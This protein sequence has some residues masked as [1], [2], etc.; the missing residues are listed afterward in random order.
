MPIINVKKLDENAGLPT[1]GSEFSAG[2][3]LYALCEEELVFQP[4][5]T[6]FVRT[7]LAME[8]PEGY[9]GLIYARSGLACKRGLA[10][11]HKGGGV[12]SD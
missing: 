2:A 10:P 1:Y 4:N 12:D 8:I 3:D 11:A 7:G 9:A 5:E 6:K